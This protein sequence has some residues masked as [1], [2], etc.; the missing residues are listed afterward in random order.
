MNELFNFCDKLDRKLPKLAEK[1][2]I[3]TVSFSDDGFLRVQLGDNFNIILTYY[4]SEFG[5]E[6]F[7]LS[8]SSGLEDSERYHAI[9][10]PE[11]LYRKLHNSLRGLFLLHGEL[12]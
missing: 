1:H 7:R 9:E 11:Y 3:S 5:G 6:E 8:L 12:S 10:I 4:K 2:G